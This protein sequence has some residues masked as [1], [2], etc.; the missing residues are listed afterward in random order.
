M[1]PTP[2]KPL[3][4]FGTFDGVGGFGLGIRAADP[5]AECVGVSEIDGFA[6]SVLRHHA[7]DVENH[8]DISG[9]A[10]GGVADFDLLVGGVPCQAWSV[11]GGR[12]GFEDP[13]GQ[14]WNEFARAAATKRPR[15]FIGENVKGLLSHDKGRSF[16]KIKAMLEATGYTVR[17]GVLNAAHFGVPHRRERVFLVGFRDQ[18]DADR[19]AFPEATDP[20]TIIGDIL[21]DEVAEKYYLKTETARKLLAK[22]DPEKLMRAWFDDPTPG[23]I[24]E[25]TKDTSQS[26]RIYGEHGAAPTLQSVDLKNGNKAPIILTTPRGKNPGRAARQA[27]S[28]TGKAWPENNAVVISQNQ[29]GE[30]RAG[31]LAGALPASQSAKQRQV[32]LRWQNKKAG[33][34]PSLTA[35]S[36]RAHEAA[37][38]R[39]PVVVS[40]GEIKPTSDGKA[41]CLDASYWKGMDNHGMRT[42][43]LELYESGDIRLRRLTP[44]EC[45]RLQGWPDGWTA[46]G[47]TPGMIARSGVP[48][49]RVP[50][51]DTQRY[52]MAGNGVAAPVV[53][54]L[55]REIIRASA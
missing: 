32:I 20:D 41:N 48:M 9:I 43:I 4:Y 34:V 46:N 7:P 5:G 2:K 21:E 28:L 6:S 52:K 30:V 11:A 27:G 35:P 44:L 31:S 37:G 24:G 54:A 15:W 29:R 50:T 3:R 22:L 36:L 40:H 42:A 1:T 23:R 19:F 26:G 18:A 17:H 38:A 14:L 47:C 33:L 51:S 8:G 10:W 49:A 39:Q 25:L 13:R 55:V 45:E 53:A 16:E 12:G